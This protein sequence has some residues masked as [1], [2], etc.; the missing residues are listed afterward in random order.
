MSKKERGNENL[1]LVGCHVDI[2][3]CLA[4]GGANLS[5]PDVNGAYPLH[6][7]AQL[8]GGEN[9]DISTRA[10]E[11]LTILLEKGADPDVRDPEGRTPLMWAANT[12]GK[13]AAIASQYWRTKS[14]SRH[15]GGLQ[16]TRKL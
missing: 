8:C 2:V 6:Y 16:G 9:D 10:L 13:N 15:H 7:T 3:Y 1:L 14:V 4:E 11:C 5:T 12:A